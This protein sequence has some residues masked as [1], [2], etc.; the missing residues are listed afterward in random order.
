MLSMKSTACSRC[1]FNDVALVRKE[2][3][4]SG[5]YRKKWRCPRCSNTWETL[6]D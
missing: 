6:E 3:L 4:G 2:M 1:G 5:K